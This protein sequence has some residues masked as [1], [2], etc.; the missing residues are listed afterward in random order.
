LLKEYALDEESYVSSAVQK[1]ISVYERWLLLAEPKRTGV[2]VNFIDSRMFQLLCVMVVVA[3][4]IFATWVYEQQI[5]TREELNVRAW[6]WAFLSFYVVELCARMVC[7]RLYF[8]CNHEAARL[9]GVYR[10]RQ[11][12]IITGKSTQTPMQLFPKPIWI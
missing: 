10:R 9:R 8:F 3:N 5:A 11:Y 4:T 2:L 12:R 1:I 7:H 6:D